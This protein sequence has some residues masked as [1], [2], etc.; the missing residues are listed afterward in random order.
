M[1][2]SIAVYTVT[3]EHQAFVCTRLNGYTYDLFENI[4]EVILFLNELE[5][6]CLHASIAIMPKQLNGFNY[7]NQTLI[8]LF[9]NIH[10]H[11]AKW[12]QVFL[13]TTSNSIKY[14][15][16]FY[17]VKLSILISRLLALS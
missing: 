17:T 5:R 1:V 12:F 9:N 11:T 10:L 16:F 8:I 4:L 15:S 2:L 3:I 6:I 14:Q 13:C 7:C